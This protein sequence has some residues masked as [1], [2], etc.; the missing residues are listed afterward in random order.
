MRIS[1]AASRRCIAFLM[2]VPLFPAHA[3]S[4]EIPNLS[5][6]W[7]RQ[8]L[9]WESPASGPGPVMNT[10]LRPNGMRNSDTRVG[11]YTDPTLTPF[12]AAEVKR[13]GEISLSGETF[14]DPA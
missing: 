6:L 3:T 11:D 7:G 9:D 4:A 8:S 1:D 5:G 2:V 14:P 13:H 10:K 12:A